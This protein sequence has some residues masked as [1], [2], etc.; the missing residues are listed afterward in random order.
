MILVVLLILL[1]LVIY[2]YFTGIMGHLLHSI[3]V[4][5]RMLIVLLV[6]AF[7]L[8]LIIYLVVKFGSTF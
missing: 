8:G 3:R 7:V 4:A 5:G 6:V 2:F 1:I